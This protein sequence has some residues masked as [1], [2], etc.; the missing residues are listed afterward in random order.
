MLNPDI[1]TRNLKLETEGKKSH[2]LSAGASEGGNGGLRVGGGPAGPAVQ[3]LLQD[4]AHHV[5][6]VVVVPQHVLAGGEAVRVAHLLH[7]VQLLVVE[8]GLPDLAPVSM[9][10]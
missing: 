9:R 6:V 1:A 7:L 8:V 3:A 5:G 2:R 4:P 10:R